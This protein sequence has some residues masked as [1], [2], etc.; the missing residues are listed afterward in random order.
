MANYQC[1]INFLTTKLNELLNGA[2]FSFQNKANV[3]IK[4]GLYA[5]F[6]GEVCIYIG[7]SENLKQRLNK[8][9]NPKLPCKNSKEWGDADTFV[10]KLYNRKDLKSECQRKHFIENVYSFEI[11]EFDG[12]T[13]DRKKL[14][15][16]Y[17]AVLEPELND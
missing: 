4:P 15:H 13:L 14:E 8:H 9:G 3:S 1:R 11:Q 17:I 7:Q 10:K 6:E 2:V 5:I 16:F 12:C